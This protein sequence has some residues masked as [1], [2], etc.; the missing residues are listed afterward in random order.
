MLKFLLFIL[1]AP[2]KN[3]T[4]GFITLFIGLTLFFR[5]FEL[6]P[7]GEKKELNIGP[8]TFHVNSVAIHRR[9]AKPIVESGSSDVQ[10]AQPAAADPY[11]AFVSQPLEPAGTDDLSA[12]LLPD[13]N[14]FALAPLDPAP[15][16]P[17]PI[18]PAPA[19]AS[20]PAPAPSRPVRQTVSYGT[21]APSAP[22]A[23]STTISF[24]PPAPV[25]RQEI[26]IGTVC[27]NRMSLM[28][29]S[30]PV[31]QE[32]LVRTAR[33]FDLLAVQGF[34]DSDLQ[35]IE[36]WVRA[37]NADGGTFGYLAAY[38]PSFKQDKNYQAP[39]VAFIFNRRAVDAD[40]NTLLVLECGTRMTC[41]PIAALFTAR[42]TDKYPAFTFI[43][44]NVWLD[45][46]KA[47]SEISVLNQTFPMLRDHIPGE[48]DIVILG[49][50][51]LNVNY[52]PEIV[53]N[54]QL[55]WV[56][57]KPFLNYYNQSA[58]SNILFYD[59]SCTEYRNDGGTFGVEKLTGL[60]A[61]QIR[62]FIPTPPIWGAFSVREA[63]R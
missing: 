55:K 35:A 20:A 12:P 9:V 45:P 15:F 40:K 58:N 1:L 26:R 38:P 31:V 52:S 16:D 13:D 49:D 63:K 7:S 14:S 18:D 8:M 34:Y 59:N 43:A 54:P 23:E 22:K 36:Q 17:A 46:A 27:L 28:K 11:N 6:Q 47:A 24:T 29:F 30:D 21:T 10:P 62:S 3:R 33:E 50:F 37:L 44:M 19:P 41:A 39:Y 4:I 48:D 25:T 51:G 53:R 2:F 56:F 61:S 32:T 60:P 42:S 57:T 5:Y